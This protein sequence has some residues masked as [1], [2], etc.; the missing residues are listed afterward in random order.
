[1]SYQM[2]KNPKFNWSVSR[3]RT[4]E[5]CELCYGLKYYIPHNGWNRTAD[6]LARAAYRVKHSKQLQIFYAN[7]LEDAIKRVFEEGTKNTLRATPEGMEKYLKQRLNQ[8]V[9]DSVNMREQWEIKPREIQMLS[10]LLH[11]TK[12][13]AGIIANVKEQMDNNINMFFQSKSYHQM[14]DHGTTYEY[15]GQKM[16][17]NFELE[18]LPNVKMY[19]HI[20]LLLMEKGT[21]NLT[22][23]NYRTTSTKTTSMQLASIFLGIKYDL[24]LPIEN[25]VVRDEN[26]TTG[27]YTELR[28]DPQDE[29]EMIEEILKSVEKMKNYVVDGDLEKNECLPI[30]E[31]KR[32]KEHLDSIYEGTFKS[33]PHCVAVK[34]ELKKMLFSL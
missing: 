7:I 26:L 3:H 29:E 24:K 25:I 20:P 19:Y 30:S 1:M 2:T 14:R 32:S 33:C 11:T 5:A 8:A 10:E 21:N 34:R 23:I 13:D 28:L 4:M 6:D 9:K 15:I 17:A 12:M 16:F 22:V 31:L 27:R 18:A